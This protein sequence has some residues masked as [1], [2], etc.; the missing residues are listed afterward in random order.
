MFDLTWCLS[1]VALLL[2]C[3]VQTAVGFGMALVA[4]PII[5]VLNP[6]WVPYVL[7]VTAL[8]L[9]LGNTWN[10]RQHVQWRQIVP[11]MISRIPGTMLGTW[12]LMTLDTEWL[13]ILV[14]GM[15]MLAILV[16]LKLKPFPSTT[17][18]MSIAGFVSGITGTTTSIGG[19]PMAL[20][21]QHSAGHHARANLSAYFVYS[22]I[23]SLIGYMTMDLMTTE[24]WISSLTMIPIAWLG[25]YLGKRLRPWVDNRFRPVL[26][27]L[28]G[29][30]A[31]IALINAAMSI[32]LVA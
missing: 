17:T 15:V 29:L 8:V 11:P 24:L 6:L 25:F 14:A 30:S 4:A 9:S 1:A 16:T 20:V 32:V 31:S 26:L 28:C 10:Q 19:P 12:I 7:A 5:V 27:A 2:G 22:C 13:Q 3:T 21:M 23:V 18:N